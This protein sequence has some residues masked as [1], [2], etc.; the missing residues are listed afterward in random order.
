MRRGDRR[1][2]AR[3][4]WLKVEYH[5]VSMSDT[6]ASPQ[7]TRFA[8]GTII[9]LAALIAALFSP[10]AVAFVPV[11]A[12]FLLILVH[13]GLLVDTIKALW[14][15]GWIGFILVV[16][17]CASMA[18]TSGSQTVML[19]SAALAGLVFFG[20][21]AGMMTV[22]AAGAAPNHGLIIALIAAFMGFLVFETASAGF[23]S[24]SNRFIGL[25]FDRVLIVLSILVWPLAGTIHARYGKVEAAI[26]IVVGLAVFALLRGFGGVAV[27]AV[28][29]IAFALGFASLAA[30]RWLLVLGVLVFG[31]CVPLVIMFAYE[32]LSAA[33]EQIGFGASHIELWG[34]TLE[35]WVESPVF[36]YGVTATI[37]TDSGYTTGFSDLILGIGA[38]GLVLTLIFF[39]PLVSAA[40]RQGPDGWHGPAAAA[41]VAT[42]LSQA[43]VFGGIWNGAWFGACGAAAL[44]IAAGRVA[45]ETGGSLGSIFESAKGHRDLY[46]LRDD[47]DA[48]E[49]YDRLGDSNYERDE[50]RSAGFTARRAAAAAAAEEALSAA[51]NLPEEEDEDE[52]WEIDLAPPASDPGGDRR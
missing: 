10:I 33:A 41:T 1:D 31:L 18:L 12:A 24:E 47:N 6:S 21:P 13:R 44:L 45:Q 37:P 40:V 17:I 5:K 36:G 9:C 34:A 29:V 3:D 22:R 26:W 8:D 48:D 35:A 19:L 11:A 4:F 42:I 20:L 32:P 43:V 46:A 30:V 14:P 7:S 2:S 16:W 28:G 51:R 39:V 25:T 23:L 38:V 52:A 15:L 27:A 49:N 50:A